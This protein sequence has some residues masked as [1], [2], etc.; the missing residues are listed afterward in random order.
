MSREVSLRSPP[1][2]SRG[3]GG[4]YRGRKGERKKKEDRGK[5]KNSAATRSRFGSKNTHSFLPLSIL[6]LL[7]SR[8][9]EHALHFCSLSEH[10]KGSVLSSLLDTCSRESNSQA[11]RRKTQS[12][13]QLFRKQRKKQRRF[14]ESEVFFWMVTTTTLSQC[15]RSC[16]SLDSNSAAPRASRENTAYRGRPAPLA[17]RASDLRARRNAVAGCHVVAASAPAS[18]TLSTFSP[19]SPTSHDTRKNLAVSV[20]GLG[21]A[22]ALLP[23]RPPRKMATASALPNSSSANSDLP[24]AP[25]RTQHLSPSSFHEHGPPASLYLSSSAAAAAAA[26]RRLVAVNPRGSAAFAAAAGSGLRLRPRGALS[27]VSLTSSFSFS[28][29]QTLAPLFPSRRSFSSLLLFF[30]TSTSKPQQQ[31]LFLA[32]LGG[33]MIA[34]A[35]SLVASNT[36]SCEACKGFGVC[37]CPVCGGCVVFFFSSSIFFLFSFASV[38]RSARKTHAFS[39]SFLF[40]PP[41]KKT[42]KQTKNI[43]TEQQPG[44]RRL[45]GQVHPLGGRLPALPRVPPDLVPGMRRAGR[46]EAPVLAREKPEGER[47]RGQQCGPRGRFEDRRGRQEEK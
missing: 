29:P 16:A 47:R 12:F 40:L 10:T 14:R 31:L 26:S 43:R 9:G 25:V 17:W 45:R 21:R 20:L 35:A 8:K 38:E 42:N 28:R 6:L 46:K 2:R 34:A 13:F 37:R 15:C 11:G 7:F 39:L 23:A 18:A 5:N 44:P 33:A 32:A 3:G 24:P 19:S 36:R 27:A 4:G 1:C 41:C 22:T 30:Q